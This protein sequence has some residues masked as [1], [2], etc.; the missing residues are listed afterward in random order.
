MS[1][2]E[3]IVNFARNFYVLSEI[4]YKFES[5][6]SDRLHERVR[7]DPLHEFLCP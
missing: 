4:S 1:L 2:R 3:N 5:E 7:L 6:F